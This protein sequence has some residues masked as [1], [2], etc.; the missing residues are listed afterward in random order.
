M[1]PLLAALKF[2]PPILSAGRAI[3]EAFTGETVAANVTPDDLA[4]KIE[5]LPADQREAVIVRVLE[6]HAEMQAYDTQRFVSM[7]DGDADKIRATARPEIALRAMAVIETFAWVFKALMAVT[8]IEWAG[9]MVVASFGL[10]WPEVS[11]WA[12]IAKA[13]PV[14]TMI[15][16]PLIASFWACLEIIRKYMGVR[17]RDKAQEYEI[18]AGRPL[19]SAAATV[20][21]AGGGIADIIKAIRG[22]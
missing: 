14:T 15:W 2:A 12:L 6:L 11:L 18:K 5:A 1:A 19:E 4:Q 9:R 3:Y 8:V 13:E 17:E 7:N 16:P 22:K 21:A 20:A 10:A